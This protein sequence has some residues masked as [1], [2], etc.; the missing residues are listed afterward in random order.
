MKVS[1]RIEENDIIDDS[2]IYTEIGRI[3]HDLGTTILCEADLTDPNEIKVRQSDGKY[4][5][6]SY[7]Y[8]KDRGL[9]VYS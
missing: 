7:T 9:D 8:I 5:P 2:V 3:Y 4:E 6:E 1:W